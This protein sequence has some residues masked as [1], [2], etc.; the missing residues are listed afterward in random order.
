MSVEHLMIY[1][2][3]NVM[4]LLDDEVEHELVIRREKFS[5]GDSRDVKRRKLR[6]IMK[7]QRDKNEFTFSPLKE[8]QLEVEFHEIDEKLAKIRR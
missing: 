3:M 4:H 7:L 8:E 5:S 2:S 1:Q 6:R